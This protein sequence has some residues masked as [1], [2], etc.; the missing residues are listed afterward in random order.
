MSSNRRTE[1]KPGWW[2]KRKIVAGVVLLALAVGLAAWFRPRIPDYALG[3][4]RAG[5]AARRV[6][7]PDQRLH[8]YLEARYGS[9]ADPAV[10]E[11]VF[12]DFFNL[13]RIK[14]LQWLV[15]QVPDQRQAESIQAMAR[16]VESYRNSLSA[17]ERATLQKQFATEQG[18]AMLRQAT[19]QYNSQ[20]VEYRGQTAGVI[21]QLLKTI[22]AAQNQ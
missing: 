17:A 12:L 11:R 6:S 1:P 22:N 5:L 7:D 20:D 18:R 10:R 15:Q 14:A 19:A 4:I 2:T 16:W 9:L 13:E 21:S 8:T 3:D